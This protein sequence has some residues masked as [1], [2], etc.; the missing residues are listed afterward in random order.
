MKKTILFSFGILILLILSSCAA[1]I[2]QTH[3]SREKNFLQYKRAY[4]EL[5]PK[6]EFNIASFIVAY[7][8]EM[9][10]KV[11]GLPPPQVLEETDLIIKYRYD[12]GWDLN[13]YLKSFQVHF[14]DAQTGVVIGLISYEKKMLGYADNRMRDA[15]NEFRRTL[16][17]PESKIKPLNKFE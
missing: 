13:K 12:D 16:G 1:T 3:V 4:L 9:G 2:M 11:I 14:L 15:F 6:D 10:I 7:V 8:N 5:L 17:L